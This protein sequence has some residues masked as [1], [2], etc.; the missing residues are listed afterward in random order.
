MN[1]KVSY[2]KLTDKKKAK[3]MNLLNISMKA[4]EEAENIGRKAVFMPLLRPR[5]E[6][7][8]ERAESTYTDYNKNCP[9]AI[10]PTAMNL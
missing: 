5:A 1:M 7:L 4:K 9:K 2:P 6:K 10:R 8:A 3:C